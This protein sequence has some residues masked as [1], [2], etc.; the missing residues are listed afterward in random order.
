MV[1]SKRS[2]W[3]LVNRTRETLSTWKR[4]LV[5]N[6]LEMTRSTQRHGAFLDRSYSCPL[7]R[8][9]LALPWER[10]SEKGKHDDVMNWIG[11]VF[12]L[13]NAPDSLLSNNWSVPEEC[14]PEKLATWRSVDTKKHGHT[15]KS[16]NVLP[17][18]DWR[19]QKK[20]TTMW[21]HVDV[22]EVENLAVTVLRRRIQSCRTRLKRRTLS[23]A[24]DSDLKRLSSRTI[25]LVK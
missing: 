21:L 14:S 19:K 7:Q 9:L 6:P 13:S 11:C 16:E 12:L 17:A 5:E 20:R 23:L 1:I 3:F 15:T 18:L 8:T 4:L 25:W 2:C 24:E 22:A 10:G